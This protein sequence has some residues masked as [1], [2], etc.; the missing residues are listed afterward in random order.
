MADIFRIVDNEYTEQR[1][2]KEIRDRVDC[3]REPRC[4]PLKYDDDT[5]QIYLD[6]N[7][8]DGGKGRYVQIRRLLFLTTWKVLPDRRKLITYCQNHRCVNPAH[9][10]YKGFQPPYEI[11]EGLK[12]VN[13]LTDEQATLWYT[14]KNGKNSKKKSALAMS[15]NPVVKT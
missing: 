14:R 10:R 11:V 4:W 3:C 13:W 9:A 6:R 5:G 8:V 15:N 12:D 7:T 1:I 2:W